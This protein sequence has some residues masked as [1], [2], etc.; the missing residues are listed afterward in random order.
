MTDEQRSKVAELKAAIAASTPTAGGAPQEV[1]SA[2]VAP[3]RELR[4]EGTTARV[5]AAAL[6]IHETTLCRWSY[7]LKIRD[8]LCAA[9]GAPALSAILFALHTG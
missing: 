1:R 7:T 3:K 6:G 8:A 4:R 5:L 9:L 2:A